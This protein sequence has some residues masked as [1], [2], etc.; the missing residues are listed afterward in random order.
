MIT[1]VAD[2][3]PMYVVKNEC[4]RKKKVLHH[5]RLLLWL[6]DF[7][8]PMQMDCMCTSVTLLRPN[9]ENPLPGSEDGDPVLG[10]MQYGLN[11]A[12]LWIIGDTPE[13]T[14]CW[15]AWEVCAGA[16]QNGTSLLIES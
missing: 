7:S 11:L 10:C 5:S 2:G 8:E 14:M 4:T 16:P 12:N 15:I 3:V 13:S 9:K 1:H 6:A